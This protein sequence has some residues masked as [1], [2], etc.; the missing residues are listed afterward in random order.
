[1]ADNSG[2][3]HKT[4]SELMLQDELTP[5]ELSYLLGIPLQQI[6]NACFEG[7]LKANIVDHDILSIRREDALQWMNDRD[8]S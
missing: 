4:M 6:H 7:E 2:E 8:Q 1:M 5:Q 3:H